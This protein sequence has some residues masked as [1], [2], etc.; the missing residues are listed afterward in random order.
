AEAGNLR[1]PEQLEQQTR[2][3]LL[4][5]K[6]KELSE[7]FVPQWLKITGIEG[8]MPDLDLFPEFYRLKYLPTAMK[9]EALLLFETIL[10]EDRSVLDLIDPDFIWLNGTLQVFYGIDAEQG[11]QKNASLFW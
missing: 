4:D 3:M 11:R 6:L 2:R 10:V 5:P 7:N 1:D 9:Q 8:A